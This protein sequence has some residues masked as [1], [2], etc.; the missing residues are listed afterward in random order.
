MVGDVSVPNLNVSHH[1][2]SYFRS[3]VFSS[4]F[5][6]EAESRRELGV[7][8]G[9]LMHA[10]GIW[11]PISFSLCPQSKVPFVDISGLH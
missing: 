7:V 4:A 2:A 8:V 11:I 9:F 1:S 6:G 3:F 10:A 5:D